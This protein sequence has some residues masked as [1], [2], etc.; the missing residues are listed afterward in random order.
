M[1]DDRE[2]MYEGRIVNGMFSNE[3]GD[4][5][6]EFFEFTLR[7]P[8]C[9]NGGTAIRCPCTSVKCQN[10]KFLNV[11]TVKV[12]LY[13]NGFVPD[14]YVWIYHGEKQVHQRCSSSVRV[15]VSETDQMISDNMNHT[16]YHRMVCDAAGPEF[17]PDEEP[18]AE[19]RNFYDMIRAGDKPVYEGNS[20]HTQLSAAV[21]ML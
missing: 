16:T 18:N 9:V 21:R 17:N 3:W 6:D 12:H 4:K 20:K 11:E 15:S 2:W 13:R 19:A 7:H 14:Y 1:E 8:E 10:K 5:V